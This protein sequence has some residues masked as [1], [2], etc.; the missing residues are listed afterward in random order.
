MHVLPAAQK[1]IDALPANRYSAIVADIEDMKIGRFDRVR[2][3]QL[4]GE[5]RELISGRHRISYFSIDSA[6][7]FVRGFPKKSAKTPRNEIEYAEKVL[8][9]MKRGI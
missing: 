1:Y 7:Y 6:L 4:L 2:T 9:M 5:I 3:K 8:K